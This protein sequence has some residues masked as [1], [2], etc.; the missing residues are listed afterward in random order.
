[1]VTSSSDYGFSNKGTDGQNVRTTF[2]Y[3]MYQQFLAD[4][5][6][7]SDLLA[8]APF[9]RVNA[10][11][12]GQA[13]IATSFISTGNYYQALGVGARIGRT[14]RSRRRQ[15]DRAAGRG[16]QLEVLAH[17]LRRPTRPSSARRSASTTS[18]SRSSACCRRTS[19]ACSSRSARPPD[20]AL[21]L[22]LDPQLDTV[23]RQR[24]AAPGASRPTGGC[25]SWAG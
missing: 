7:M 13:E 19:P 1:M 17:A 22:A 2:S 18:P 16:D 10:V 8:F 23:H 5:Q 25:R 11:V 15:A 9:G 21:P 12:D 24:T 6:T 4:N 20:I 14:I 3:P